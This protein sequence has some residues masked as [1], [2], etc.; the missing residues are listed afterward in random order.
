METIWFGNDG[1]GLEHFWHPV[2]FSHEVTATTL[3]RVELL[4]RRWT[5][6]RS[7]DAVVGLSDE[8]AHRRASLSGGCIVDG[9]IEC[10]YHGWRYDFSGRCVKVPALAEHLAPPERAVLTAPHAV[11]ERAG[12]IWMA[13]KEPAEA[14]IDWPQW[15]APE[16]DAWWL[17]RRT[18]HVSAGL[19]TENFLDGTHFAFVHRNTFG[20]A[21]ASRGMDYSDRRDWRMTAGLVHTTF[22]PG[23]GEVTATVTSE[24]QGPFCLRLL[25]D[26][27]KGSRAFTFFLQPCNGRETRLY[28][29]VACNDTHGDAP[30]MHAET[31]FNDEVY[32]EDLRVLEDYA[33]PRVP[34]DSRGEISTSADAN[35]VKYRR[36]LAD[37]T[38]LASSAER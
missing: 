1:A 15:H 5:L 2:A 9:T 20:A 7:G 38:R 12:L 10:P 23:L 29:G 32:D 16:W 37:V 22:Q 26:S 17:E 36:M 3:T 25:I 18:T 28:L 21:T 31:V 27:G 24:L 30:L 4:G 14:I 8:C 19:L 34:L 33:D 11:S 35:L 6:T 13:I